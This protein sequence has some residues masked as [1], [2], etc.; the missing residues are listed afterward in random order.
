MS[1]NAKYKGRKPDRFF[2]QKFSDAEYTDAGELKVKGSYLVDKDE[3]DEA[4]GFGP[5]NPFRI[6]IPY[7]WDCWYYCRCDYNGADEQ[8]YRNH[9]I[10]LWWEEL[11]EEGH[12]HRQLRLLGFQRSEKTLDIQFTTL[13]NPSVEK[14]HEYLGSPEQMIGNVPSELV[15]HHLHDE[16]IGAVFGKVNREIVKWIC[17][18][19]PFWIRSPKY[20]GEEIL[21]SELL[22]H[23]F[24]E[25][26]VPVCLKSAVNE[27]VSR[28]ELKWLL[29]YVIIGRGA[30]LT[31]VGRS[32]DWDIPK[33]LVRELFEVPEFTS[34]RVANLYAFMRSKGGNERDFQRICENRFFVV[35]PTESFYREGQKKFW[36]DTIEWV[37][38]NGDNMTDEI[39]EVV[40]EWAVH[41]YTETRYDH[42]R[43]KWNGRSLAPTI[44]RSLQYREER[45]TRKDYKTWEPKDWNWTYVDDRSRNIAIS[46]IVS[47][48]KLYEEG[49]R[50]KHC[51]NMYTG[52]CVLGHSAI[53]SFTIDGINELTLEVDPR[54]KQLVQARGLQNRGSTRSEN[55]LIKIWMSERVDPQ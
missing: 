50:M 17:L 5:W 4:L 3:V 38:S 20:T 6:Y 27:Q 1:L 24:C 52:R 40:L 8:D 15:R 35:D 29:W 54:S 53:F 43:F 37:I 44:R 36:N 34:M 51:V 18:L 19:S 28:P 25:Y 16:R 21:T 47:S 11:S 12:L 46:E 26:P 48:D 31:K 22:D 41:R 33:K 32:F 7:C 13:E 23:L 10:E 55:D 14:V 9:Q 39:C 42:R 49:L 2:E 45:R 30:S